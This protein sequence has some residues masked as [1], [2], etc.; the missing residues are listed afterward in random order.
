MGFT[1]S[2]AFGQAPASA[3]KKQII[4]AYFVKRFI[5][6]LPPNSIFNILIIKNNNGVPQNAAIKFSFP[7]QWSIIGLNNRQVTINPGD[8]VIIPIRLSVSSNTK[9]GIANVIGVNIANQK[10]EVIGSA[11]CYANIKKNQNL[12]ISNLRSTYYL[13]PEQDA[14]TC[15]FRIQNKGNIHEIVT[16]DF[17]GK[18]TLIIEGSVK[19]KITKTVTVPPFTD[20][21][22]TYNVL[23]K[24]STNYFDRQQKILQLHA[25]IFNNENRLSQTILYK[26]LQ[27]QYINESMEVFHPLSVDLR[28]SNI[29]SN[30]LPNINLSV[31]GTVLLKPEGD[32]TYRFHNQ[33]TSIFSPNSIYDY[34]Y[35]VGYRYKNL[36]IQ[37][38]DISNALFYYYMK[39]ISAEYSL[40]K[41]HIR[42]YASGRHDL[43]IYTAGTQANYQLL[44]KVNLKASVEGMTNNGITNNV[45]YHIEKINTTIGLLKNQT[46]GLSVLH[47]TLMK[48]TQTNKNGFGFEL[49]YGLSLKKLHIG[50]S[51][52]FG[53][54]D[55]YSRMQQEPRSHSINAEYSINTKSS[56]VG[57]YSYNEHKQT[58]FFRDSIYT[59]ERENYQLGNLRFKYRLTPMVLVY[60]GIKGNSLSTNRYS[61]NQNEPFTVSSLYWTNSL[62]IKHSTIDHF[63]I[64]PSVD[65]GYS[66]IQEYPDTINGRFVDP[67]SFD[68]KLNYFNTVAGV[69]LRFRYS[70]ITMK[71]FYGP[72]SLSNVNYLFR[73]GQFSKQLRINAYLK[74][75]IYRDQLELLSS[76]NFLREMSNTLTRFYINNAVNWYLPK[77][78]TITANMTYSVYSKK[79]KTEDRINMSS[80]GYIELGVKKDF[81]WQQPRYKFY[82]MQAVFFIDYNGDRM[83]NENEPGIENI[84]VKVDYAFGDTLK[85][86]PDMK[87]FNTVELVTDQYGKISYK[88]IPRGIYNLK[89]TLLQELEGNY[90]AASDNINININSNSTIYIPFFESNTIHGELTFKRDKFT[91]LGKLNLKGIRVVAKDTMGNS[92]STLTN[93]EGKFILSVPRAGHYTV[94]VNNIFYQNFNLEQNSFIIDFN[95]YKQYSLTFVFIEKERKINF[96]MGPKADSIKQAA[97]KPGSM[98]GVTPVIQQ[99][100]T[101]GTQAPSTYVSDIT[102]SKAAAYNQRQKDSIA[103]LNQQNQYLTG[104]QL[105]AGSQQTTTSQPTAS[106]VFDQAL[107]KARYYVMAGAYKNRNTAEK[108]VE[109]LKAKGFSKAMLVGRTG[110]GLYRIC[111]TYA[112]TNRQAL[113]ELSKIRKN[114]TPFVWLLE[115]NTTANAMKV[116]SMEY[117]PAAKLPSS[118]TAVNPF[119][120]GTPL[121]ETKKIEPSFE[122]K[123][124]PKIEA[125]KGRETTTSDSSSTPVTSEQPVIQDSAPATTPSETPTTPA[126]TTPLAPTETSVVE[127]TSAPAPPVEVANPPA[128]TAPSGDVPADIQAILNQIETEPARPSVDTAQI[129]NDI[130]SYEQDKQKTDSI[131]KANTP[132]PTPVSETPK[133]VTPVAPLPE[134]IV[135][136]L[137]NLQAIRVTESGTVFKVQFQ[138]NENSLRKHR[139]LSGLPDLVRIEGEEEPTNL[140]FSETFFKYEDAKD[141]KN[142]LKD[143]GL[144][145][146]DVIPFKD[147]IKIPFED[148]GLQR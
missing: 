115:Q 128:T 119:A 12:K 26:T 116:S 64:S 49:N 75:F 65:I 15:S 84:L 132:P 77:S 36:F 111:Y 101:T 118:D 139:E 112:E 31:Y 90:H 41:F 79:D 99:N 59:S 35:M 107:S 137:G 20:T 60:S 63:S 10:D 76:A 138:A 7:E 134:N 50:L 109:E 1:W 32:L 92:W 78:W 69:S 57:D 148:T 61:F 94:T 34:Y 40:N 117:E 108:M 86:T 145:D 9:G 67:N 11:F 113:A 125:I 146:V 68:N 98:Q 83:K 126:E 103:K 44:K 66:A 82:N 89:Y 91:A 54:K 56:I 96:S 81:N 52:T 30:S 18:N 22:V 106:P 87:Y 19:N 37:L 8:S 122:T 142:A 46:I 51:N 29:F 2:F 102:G 130:N 48:E 55:F 16:F 120:T 53:G 23:R 110:D 21:V 25:S 88:K 58:H 95:G 80:T 141:Y 27:S 136:Q 70:G 24:S 85:A 42:L 72:T 144:F 73:D 5:E 47:S 93:E 104:S 121:R 147:G 33:N 105:N 129:I 135:K 74:R 45:A 28:F 114:V 131:A 43:N 140:Y 13:K 6:V 124:L 127:P 4:Q 133:P 17:E 100:I 62:N 39:G 97:M 143:L 14:S 71:Y 3:Q 38:G 123:N